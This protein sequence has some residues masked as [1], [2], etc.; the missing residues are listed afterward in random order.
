VSRNNKGSWDEKIGWVVRQRGFIS[1]RPSID[2][3]PFE[4]KWILMGFGVLAAPA[5]FLQEFC[6]AA[7]KR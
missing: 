5:F 7:V 6:N 4:A 2:E 3:G 1:E